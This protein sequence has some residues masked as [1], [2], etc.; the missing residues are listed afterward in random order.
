M[1][2]KPAFKVVQP[3]SLIAYKIS[4]DD[5]VRLVVLASPFDGW[6]ATVV[7]EIWDPDGS[8]PWNSHPLST[9]T[10]LF[11]QGSGVAYSDD[12]SGPVSSGQFLILPPGSRHR[13]HNTSPT[14][15]YA[16]TTMSPDDGFADLI[17]GGTPVPLEPRDLAVLGAVG[18][19]DAPGAARPADI[20]QQL[21]VA[22][23]ANAL[24]LLP[25]WSGDATEIKVTLEAPDY[26]TAMM[27]VN[28]MGHLGEE[29]GHHADMDI[30]WRTVTIR[31]SSHTFRG[32]LPI[33]IMM[34]DRVNELCRQLGVVVVGAP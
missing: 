17:R 7:F 19:G 25:G 8:Q 30:R 28:Q 24:A 20:G 21:G 16:I 27:F 34:A 32:V 3:D 6:D 18:M 5:T 31:L 4:P 11:L 26:P 10:F 33:D 13:V 23:V 9:E 15:L 1:T 22:A 14:R 29:L 12:D 2:A